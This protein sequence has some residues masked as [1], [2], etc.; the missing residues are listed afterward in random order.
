ML[1]D[2]HKN[3]L[4]NISESIKMK[5]HRTCCECRNSKFYSCGE[6][7]LLCKKT[8]TEVCEDDCCGDFVPKE[9]TLEA[10]AK[11]VATTGDRRD[12]QNCL[13]LRREQL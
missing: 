6:Y 5:T 13:Q 9:L 7:Y 10:A 2:Y 1:A 3:N 4:F 8:E 11:R 12:L